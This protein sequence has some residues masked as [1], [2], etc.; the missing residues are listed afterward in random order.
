MFKNLFRDKITLK[1]FHG[2][3]AMFRIFVKSDELR[4]GSSIITIYFCHKNNQVI[5]IAIAED[6]S[7][8]AETLKQKVELSTDFKVAFIA[9]NGNELLQTLHR[10]HNIDVILMDINMP[11]MDG[12]EATREVSKRF[13]QIKIIICTVFD[14]EENI[15]QA[16][17][18]GANGY[19]MK[20][21]KH[22]QVHKAIF[23][24]M[25]G[26]AP[27]SSG[28]ARKALMLIRSGKPQPELNETF[29]LTKREIEILE[30]LSKGLSYDQIAGN[31]I[32]S[33]GTVRKHIENIYRKLQVNNKVEAV[34]K[35][36]QN[37][38]V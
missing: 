37:R 30:H 19:L 6:N 20:D 14:D 21:E 32:I 38:I 8:I 26:G 1:C 4:I 10:N 15:F 28:I 12:I 34:Q 33:N 31:L 36:I 9:E 35:A 7:R 24:V 3:Y 2:Q 17:L 13:P 25:E 23:E 29:D 5:T 16:I 27:M 11:V 18:A 22:E